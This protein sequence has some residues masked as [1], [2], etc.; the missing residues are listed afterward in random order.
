MGAGGIRT[1][2][3]ALSDADATS[4]DE[5]GAVA[6]V[7]AIPLDAEGRVLQVGGLEARSIS[8][9]ARELRNVPEVIAVSGGRRKAVAIRAALRSG[10]I[11]RLVT[12]EETARLLLAG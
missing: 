11:H 7:C 3:A 5:A 9:T 2:R 6:D 1:V 10:L 8:I 12:T 4:I